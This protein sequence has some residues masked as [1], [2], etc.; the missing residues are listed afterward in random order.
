MRLELEMAIARKKGEYEGLRKY[1]MD[2]AD[3]VETSDRKLEV[4]DQIYSK[5][6]RALL[7]E[8]RA[9]RS[10]LEKLEEDDDE[11]DYELWD[12]EKLQDL[13][14]HNAVLMSSLE[15]YMN[16]EQ[17]VNREKA[18]EIYEM[19]LIEQKKV[20]NEMLDRYYKF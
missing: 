2:V 15:L 14:N 11:E 10:Q 19:I 7:D 4:L 1:W 3:D 17:S 6:A 13:R 18:S 5:E 8:L 20:V 16:R 12:D 9:L